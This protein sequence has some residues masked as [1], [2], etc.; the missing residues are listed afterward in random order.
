M[1]SLG[2]LFGMS[3]SG[4]LM[5]EGSGLLLEAGVELNVV[6]F[7]LVLCIPILA[8][9]WSAR[10]MMGVQL[11]LLLLL[12]VSLARARVV[13]AVLRSRVDVDLLVGAGRDWIGADR[14]RVASGHRRNW[15]R[16]SL[17]RVAQ[18]RQRRRIVVTAAE[19]VCAAGP[20][21]RLVVMH[22]VR[23]GLRLSLLRLGMRLLMVE[24]LLSLLGLA[25]LVLRVAARIQVCESTHTM[26]V[27]RMAAMKLAISMSTSPS[28]PHSHRPRV[29]TR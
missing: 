20:H 19:G 26:M 1:S 6:V 2:A 24:L 17:L 27:S 15:R 8:R 23:L 9:R 14:T 13:L 4:Q 25:Q 3:G 29:A 10:L 7:G 11:L 28:R 16:Q 18:G 21:H 22:H 5:I 12:P